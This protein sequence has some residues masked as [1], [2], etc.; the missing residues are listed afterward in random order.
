MRAQA[1]DLNNFPADFKPGSSGAF[2]DCLVNGVVIQFGG[3]TANP[4]NQELA[5]VGRVRVGAA[6]I[7]I[8]AFDAMNQTLLAQEIQG[9]VHGRRRRTQPLS[10]E[11]GQNIVCPERSVA[12]PYQFQHPAPQGRQA[13]PI[14]GTHRSRTVESGVEALRMIVA[15]SKKRRR[16]GRLSHRVFLNNDIL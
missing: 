12:T 3:Q 10:F 15:V 16:R 13:H 2:A 5:T 8:E 11:R 1:L 9:A 6:D 4:A 7:G 14:I